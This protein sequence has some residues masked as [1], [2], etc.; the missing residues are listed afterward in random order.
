[1]KKYLLNKAIE[2]P[3]Y[4][5][6]LV[7]VLSNSRKKVKKFLPSFDRSEVYAHAWADNY[8]GQQGYYVILNFDSEFSRLDPGAIAHEATHISSYLFDI[9]G[10]KPD[11]NN[12]EPQCYLIQWVVNEVFKFIHENNFQDKIL[13]HSKG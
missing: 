6:Y 4:G 9:R 3:L 11:F 13:W 1:M 5:G 10:M 12:D 7:I 2:I 8:N